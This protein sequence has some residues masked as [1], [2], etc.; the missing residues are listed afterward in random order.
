MK[1]KME[2][3]KV[4]FHDI[5]YCPF[6]PDAKIKKFKK[7]SKLRKPGNLMIKNLEKKWLI[8]KS[9]SFMIGDS[10]TDKQT[11][12]KSKIYFEYPKKNLLLQVKSIFKK[13]N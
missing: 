9:K 11:A 1:N 6:H 8:N 5:E 7:N 4:F 10:L 12:K 3:K 13:L 2:E